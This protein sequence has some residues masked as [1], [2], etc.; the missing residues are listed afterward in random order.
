MAPREITIACG[1]V[2]VR[3]SSD[4]SPEMLQTLIA[5]VQRENA[6]PKPIPYF[7]THRPW[8]QQTDCCLRCGR[9]AAEI[10]FERSYCL[11]TAPAQETER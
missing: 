3:A 10:H 5:Y 9:S 6:K 4:D 1:D 2:Q 7:T 11:P 8:N